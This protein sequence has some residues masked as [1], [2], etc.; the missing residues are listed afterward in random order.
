MPPKGKHGSDLTKLKG[1][2]FEFLYGYI[3]CGMRVDKRF[4]L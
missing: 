1:V 2:S 3:L 4:N